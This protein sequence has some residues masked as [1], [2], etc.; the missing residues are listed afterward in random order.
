MTCRRSQFSEAISGPGV[1]F[2]DDVTNNK[3][4]MVDEIIEWIQI[5]KKHHEAGGYSKQN[6]QETSFYIIAKIS[7]LTLFVFS[8]LKTGLDR[9]KVPLA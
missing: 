1:W 5:H 2:S 4:G 9:F 6:N 7:L 3:D 8:L